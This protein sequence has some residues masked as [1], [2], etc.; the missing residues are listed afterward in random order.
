MAKSYNEK[1]GG[2]PKFPASKVKSPSS[3]PE[4]ALQNAGGRPPEKT[5]PGK[6]GITDSNDP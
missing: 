2:V 4:E 3:T 5:E 6:G 1:S